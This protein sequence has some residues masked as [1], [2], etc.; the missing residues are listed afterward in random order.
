MNLKGK[1]FW[2]IRIKFLKGPEAEF[3][4]FEPRFKFK[5]RLKF[6]KFGHRM[7]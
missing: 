6:I 1:I 7:L 3:K 4:E 2:D 5:S